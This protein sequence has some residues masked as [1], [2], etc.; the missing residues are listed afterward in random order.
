M[1]VLSIWFA[2]RQ[3]MTC[4]RELIA[5]VGE[6]AKEFHTAFMPIC[7]NIKTRSASACRITKNALQNF[8]KKWAFLVLSSDCPPM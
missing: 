8:W 7:V 5:M 3:V 1:A 2:I 6:S 4:S